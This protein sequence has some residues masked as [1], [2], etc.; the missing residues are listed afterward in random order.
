MSVKLQI[1]AKGADSSK[2]FT[3]PNPVPEADFDPSD[4]GQFVTEYGSV[5][6]DQTLNMTKA[7]YITTSET[8]VYPAA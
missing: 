6:N 4:A 1:T 2:S 7:A 8:V 5:Y 3:I